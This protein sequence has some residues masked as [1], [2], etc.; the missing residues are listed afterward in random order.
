MIGFALYLAIDELLG[1]VF[2]NN[3]LQALTDD[4]LNVVIDSLQPTNA[5]LWLRDTHQKRGPSVTEGA[6]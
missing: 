6:Q 4:M 2:R 5:S 3:D 1:S